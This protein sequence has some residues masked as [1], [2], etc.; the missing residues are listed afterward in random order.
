MNI[1]QNTIDLWIANDQDIYRDIMDA[2][3]DAS[4]VY[5]FSIQVREIVEDKLFSGVDAFQ[6]DVMMSS[7]AE[8]KW[9]EIADDFWSEY[10]EG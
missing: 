3:K 1:H 8:V 7:L 5:D 6:Q 10:V 4:N 9:N 2:L